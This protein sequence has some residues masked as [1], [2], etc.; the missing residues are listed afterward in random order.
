MT[1]SFINVTNQTYQST[2]FL[3]APDQDVPLELRVDPITKQREIFYR[4]E[5]IARL[6]G[7]NVRNDVQI[8]YY[9][10]QTCCYERYSTWKPYVS[11]PEFFSFRNDQ[12]CVWVSFH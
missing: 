1:R 7:D 8:E 11:C 6:Y 10:D 5:L 4:D 9:N 2:T 12:G 3:H